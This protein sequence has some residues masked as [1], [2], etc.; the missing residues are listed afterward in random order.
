MKAISVYDL[1]L[2]PELEK[3]S[4]FDLIHPD[5]DKLVNP[6]L[7]VMGFDLDYPLIYTVSQH[8]TLQNKV[9]VGYV[10]RGEVNI[11][12]EHLSSEWATLY[13]RMVAAAYQ[14]PT[15]CKALCEQMN[16][17]L[18]YSAFHSAKETE[19]P[20]PV[21]FPVNQCNPD[22]IVITEQIKQLEELLFHIRGSQYKKDGSLKMPA[23]Y[24]EVEEEVKPKRR[25]KPIKLSLTVTP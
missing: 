8:R 21:D 17:S 4:I 20:K 24:H 10:I 23:D 19:N 9:V 15:L 5:N 14:D 12:R 11:N 3:L 16:T 18:D 13:D 25:K 1:K 22:E 6:F 2:I 7:A